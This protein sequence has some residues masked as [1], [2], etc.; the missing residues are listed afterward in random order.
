LNPI[1]SRVVA[2]PVDSTSVQ[3]SRQVG[4]YRWVL[5]FLLFVIT[6]NNYI[7]RQMLSIAAPAIAAEYKFNNSDVAAIANAFLV[8]YTIGHL[9][10]GMFVDRVGQSRVML[11]AAGLFALTAYPAF[12]IVASHAS[13]WVLMAMVCWITLLK[14]FFS[15]ALPSLMAKIFPVQTRVTGMALSYNIS[16]PIFGGFAPLI[17]A[18]LIQLTGSK[19]APSFYLIGT[20]LVSLVALIALRARLRV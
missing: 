3:P 17:A 11:A 18:L 14:S 15:G 4:R 16:V 9:F 7:D 19:L 5:C 20:A 12:V 10:A 8:A 6:V 1:P 13:L 2:E